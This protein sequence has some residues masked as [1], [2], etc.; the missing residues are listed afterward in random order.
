MRP[1]TTALAGAYLQQRMYSQAI[2][3]FQK[4][5]TL[6]ASDPDQLMDLG[7]AFAMAGQKDAAKGILAEL[8]KQR[9][10]G[11]VAPSAPAIVSAA[12]GEKDEAFAW[13]EKAY[14]ERDPQPLHRGAHLDSSAVARHVGCNRTQASVKIILYDYFAADHLTHSRSTHH[15]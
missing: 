6:S 3:E 5:V 7:Y 8:K 15:D 9:E 11:F 12:L 10:H 4:A 2:A 13:L 1:L 14:D